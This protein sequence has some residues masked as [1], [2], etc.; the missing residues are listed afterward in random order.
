V[1]ASDLTVTLSWDELTAATRRIAGLVGGDGTPEIIVGVLRGG[2]IP[3]IMLAHH[4][5]SRD[6][7]AVE[8][9]RT[10][11]DGVNAAKAARPAWR[12][13]ASLG[14]VSGRDVLIADDVAGTGATVAATAA[15]VRAMGAARVRTAVWVVNEAD[16]PDGQPSPE[17]TLTYIGARTQG[18]VI[19]PWEQQ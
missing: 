5:G 12:N 18:W 9:T 7:R 11:A 8:I 3:A 6:V 14:G 19:F 17:K 10:L 4:L 13:L 15:L 16:W 1:A 2:M